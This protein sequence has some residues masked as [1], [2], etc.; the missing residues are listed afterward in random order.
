MGGAEARKRGHYRGKARIGKMVELTYRVT[1]GGDGSEHKVTTKNIG[2]GGA[3]LLTP[4]PLPPGTK[5]KVTLAV[6]DR[7]G[8]LTVDAEVRWIID[9]RNGSPENQHGMGVKFSG[10]GVEDTM[11]L[12]EFFASL[13]EAVELD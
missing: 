3:F 5:L 2:V 1:D 13:P 9:T 12:N 8:D 11:L 10:I 4:R 7:T 6:P